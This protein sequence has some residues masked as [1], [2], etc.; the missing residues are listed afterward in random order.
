MVTRGWLFLA[1]LMFCGLASAQQFRGSW[2]CTS[3]CGSEPNNVGSTIIADGETRAFIA[4]VVNNSVDQ[5][6]AND[7][8]AICDGSSCTVYIYSAMGSFVKTSSYDDIGQY[9]NVDT[10]GSA[11]GGNDQGSASGSHIVYVNGQVCYTCTGT[12]VV[13]PVRRR[14]G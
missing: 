6:R 10:S 3:G 2:L 4:A 5:W 13:G 11:S 7:T 12:V 14:G 8:V 9:E 1:L